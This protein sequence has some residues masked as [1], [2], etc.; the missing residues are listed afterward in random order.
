MKKYQEL[1]QNDAKTL[2]NS[3]SNSLKWS[4]KTQSSKLNQSDSNYRFTSW[5]TMISTCFKL[6]PEG[7]T[8]SPSKQYDKQNIN[9]IKSFDSQYLNSSNISYVSSYQQNGQVNF[10]YNFVMFTFI[11]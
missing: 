4:N 9:F 11:D 10:Q 1:L 2:L 6:Y 8:T 7:L 5:N 3:K